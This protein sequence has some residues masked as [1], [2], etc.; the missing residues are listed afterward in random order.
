MSDTK[1]TSPSR[2]T[3]SHR[4]EASVTAG[5]A[6]QHAAPRGISAATAYWQGVAA[7]G[8]AAKSSAASQADA[9]QPLRHRGLRA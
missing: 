6:T 1:G 8:R 2:D 7:T 4:V 9:A 3:S 5:A